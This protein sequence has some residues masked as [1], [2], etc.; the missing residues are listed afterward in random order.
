[1]LGIGHSAPFDWQEVSDVERVLNVNYMSGLHVLKTFLPLIKKARGR[2]V[3]NQK[4]KKKVNQKKTSLG[5]LSLFFAKKK[6]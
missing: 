4:K 3:G 2:V 6:V 1:M 5:S